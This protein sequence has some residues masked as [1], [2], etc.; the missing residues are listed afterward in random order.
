MEKCGS[1]K[2]MKKV[3]LTYPV[4]LEHRIINGRIT[5]KYELG[6]IWDDGVVVRVS[7]ILY[8]GDRASGL[9]R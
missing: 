9:K 5:V 4:F 7:T 1:R 6:E 2:G 8:Y 3:N